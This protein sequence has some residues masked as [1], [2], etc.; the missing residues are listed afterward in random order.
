MIAFLKLL[1]IN[2]ETKSLVK[3]EIICFVFLFLFMIG[4]SVP[5]SEQDKQT[6]EL[7]AE[8]ITYSCSW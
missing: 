6:C 1:E 7:E 5:K 4:F 8:S 2:S 3:L